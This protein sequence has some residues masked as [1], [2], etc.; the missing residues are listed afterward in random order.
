MRW[1]SGAE[2]TV[3]GPPDV[4]TL[5]EVTEEAAGHGR[6]GTSSGAAPEPAKRCLRT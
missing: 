5:I 6:L 1:L 3:P 2:Q 4:N